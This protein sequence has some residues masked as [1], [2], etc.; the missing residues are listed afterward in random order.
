MDIHSNDELDE[1][2]IAG[3]RSLYAAPAEAGYWDSLESR[4]AS[5]AA[6]VSRD[7]AW[8]SVL[9]HWAAPGLAAAAL[10]LAVAGAVWSRMDQAELR[11]TYEGFTQPMVAD[12]IPASAQLLDLPRDGSTQ[13]DATLGYV[14]SH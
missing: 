6:S 8:Y 9:A 12:A 7:G 10:L 13:R 14:L 3:M 5:A 11:S 4:I 2:V 1:A